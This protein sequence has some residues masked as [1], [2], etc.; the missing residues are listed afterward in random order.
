MEIGILG[1]GIVGTQL[2]LGFLKLGYEIK[3]GTRD[4]SKL[5]SWVKEAGTNASIGSFEDAAKF[6]ELIVIATS[7]LGAKNAIELAGKENFSN[8]TV[9]D[10]TNPLG[11]LEG[12]MPAFDASPGNSAGERIQNWLPEAKIVKAFNTVNAHTMWNP[13]REEGDPDLFIAGNNE[14]AKNEVSS[15]AKKWG[16]KRI[17]DMGDIS[18][19]I[20]LESLAMFWINYLFKYKV[21]T[22]AFKLLLK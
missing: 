8:K 3:M 9:I 2:A 21:N 13:K 4:I 11:K 1:S 6:G 18:K 19:S 16:W 17:I 10:V 20:W 14:N 15:I 12:G 7:W 5:D 22:H